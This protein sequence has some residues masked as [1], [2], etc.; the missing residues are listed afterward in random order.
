MRRAFFLTFEGI[1]GCGKST[2]AERLKRAL[3][4]RRFLVTHTFEPG[5]TMLGRKLRTI[6]VHDEL[7]LSLF[8]EVLLF[9]ADRRQDIDEVIIPALE[10]GEIVIGERFSD[11]SIAYQGIA[12]NVGKER[13]ERLM[14]IVTSGM[15]PDLTLLLD[16]DPRVAL[17]RKT[18]LDRIEQRGPFLDVVRRAFL[19]MATSQPER[20]V[21]IDAAR[22]VD[23]VFSDVLKA[24]LKRLE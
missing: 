10:R 20:W 8:S 14:D 24:V 11:S 13:V 19:D 22:P 23:D 4:E 17:A 2:Q 12:G 1:D 18:D 7:N 5:G 6:L 15:V 16:I 21:T 3:T 9:A